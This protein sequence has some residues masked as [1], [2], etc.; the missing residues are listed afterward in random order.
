MP[1][2]NAEKQARWRKRHADRRRTVARIATMLMRRQLTN[3]H[4]TELAQ[5]IALIVKR[6]RGKLLHRELGKALE[7][8]VRMAENHA[9]HVEQERRYRDDWLAA[10]PD[11]TV[12]D[13]RRLR[14]TA[15]FEW[16]I[17]RRTRKDWLAVPVHEQASASLG[18]RQGDQSASMGAG[19]MSSRSQD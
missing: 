15:V 19:E 5:R 14:K 18:D 6:R 10:H 17:A 9:E 8:L 16:L 11:M 3:K 2:T 7:V 12:K 4:T 1:L 13:F